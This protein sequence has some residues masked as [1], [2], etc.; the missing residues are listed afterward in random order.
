MNSCGGFRATN[1]AI[2]VDDFIVEERRM[3]IAR[4]PS[5]RMAGFYG[6]PNG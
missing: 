3:L 5:R 2:R 1:Y 4:I 6:T